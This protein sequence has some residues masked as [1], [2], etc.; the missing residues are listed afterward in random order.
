MTEHFIH[1]DGHLSNGQT[2]RVVGRPVNGDAEVVS[3]TITKVGQDTAVVLARQGVIGV[4]DGAG[5][6]ADVGSPEEAALVAADAVEQY[7][8]GDGDNLMAAMQYAREAVTDTPT[9]GVCVGAL[10]RLHWNT[11]ESVTA[12]DAGAF[13]YDIAS[14]SM[15]MVAEQQLH[16]YEPANYLGR[17]IPS[18]A[19]SA[20]DAYSTSP[21]RPQTGQELYAMTDGALGNWRR[22][23]DLQ[24][25]HV[26]AAHDESQLLRDA[27]VADPLFARHI[28]QR[29]AELVDEADTPRHP[30]PFTPQQVDWT[31]WEKVVKPYITELDPPRAAI[32]RWALCEALIT[33]PI[34]WPFERPHRD[35]ATIVMV[36]GTKT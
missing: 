22:G 29:L 24:D 33:R 21:Y 36:D 34:A 6:A 10:V 9:A 25:Y 31:S 3:R 13:L 30:E 35:D 27:L 32:S 23:D 28:Q 4:F 20:S 19:A 7:F 16:G 11:L 14:Q 17:P 2:F 5:G 1:R 15:S 12:G 18:I 26:Q 8:H